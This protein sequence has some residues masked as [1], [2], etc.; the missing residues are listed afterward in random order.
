M[1]SLRNTKITGAVVNSQA[2]RAKSWVD[3]TLQ[4]ETLFFFPENHLCHVEN[5]PQLPF[6]SS[7]IYQSSHPVF[8]C[9]LKALAFTLCE[10]QT[11]AIH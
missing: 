6:T 1:L 8:F 5:S 11:K 4:K 10:E 2:Q 9:F 7:H 3:V